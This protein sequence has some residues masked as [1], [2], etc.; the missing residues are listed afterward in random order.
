MLLNGE[1][2]SY[3]LKPVPESQLWLRRL[4]R[5]IR[6]EIQICAESKQAFA[7]ENAPVRGVLLPAKAKLSNDCAVTIHVFVI[8]IAEEAPAPAD[9]FHKPAPAG[10]VVLVLSKVLCQFRD[11]P[12]QEGNLDLG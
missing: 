9:Q 11:S 4:R 1:P 7:T 10:V 3:Q 2:W 12:G 8:Q 6:G 5:K